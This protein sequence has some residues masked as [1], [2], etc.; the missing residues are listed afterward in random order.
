[1]EKWKIQNN[2]DKVVR[3]E[4]T[5]FLNP[6]EIRRITKILDNKKIAYQVLKIFKDAEKQLIYINDPRVSLFLINTNEVLTHK[7]ILGTLYSHQLR[8]D[9]YGDIIVDNNKFYIVVL[10]RLKSYMVTHF[11][12]VGGVK[13]TLE[14][15][16]LSEISNYEL[17]YKEICLTLSSLRIDNV[18]AK[19]IP[20]SRSNASKLIDD[21]KII[22]NYDVLKNKTYNLKLN[23]IFSIR[24]FGK[25]KILSISNGHRGNNLHIIISKYI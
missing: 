14:E 21:K 4:N 12:E 24:G 8:E 20:T 3:G 11:N 5:N 9:C 7:Q 25:F 23:D 10:D 17:K 2:I 16:D 6:I 19:I 22:L 13:I 1:M 18:V 15:R